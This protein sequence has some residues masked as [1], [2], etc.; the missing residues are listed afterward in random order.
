[1]FDVVE[2]IRLKKA[3]VAQYLLGKINHDLLLFVLNQVVQSGGLYLLKF[4]L[5]QKILYP[6]DSNLLHAIRSGNFELEKYVKSW[7]LKDQLNN[8]LNMMREMDH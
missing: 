4:I 3:L 8:E 5:D 7:I 6:S 1:M 2:A